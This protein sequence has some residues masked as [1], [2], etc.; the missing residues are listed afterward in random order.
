MF[1]RNSSNCNGCGGG[2]IQNEWA[3]WPC[4]YCSET[5]PNYKPKLGLN[6]AFPCSY[7]GG[8]G[9]AY[10]IRNVTCRTC[11]GSGKR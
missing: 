1:G 5:D 11:G 7:C 10:S 9:S 8:K 6:Q 4:N 3:N 2:G